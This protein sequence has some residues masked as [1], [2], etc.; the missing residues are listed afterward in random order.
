MMD[1][2]DAA[3]ARKAT[4]QNILLKSMKMNVCYP[5]HLRKHIVVL[6][7]RK[8]HVTAQG[9]SVVNIVTSIT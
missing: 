4:K 1:Y 2:S 9:V 6:N 8:H 3:F 7:T 5:S